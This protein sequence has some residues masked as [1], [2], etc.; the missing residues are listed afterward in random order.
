MPT[1][2]TTCLLF[3][4]VTNQSKSRVQTVNPFTYLCTYRYLCI[5]HRCLQICTSLEE[6]TLVR[7]SESMDSQ[8]TTLAGKNTHTMLWVDSTLQAGSSL[9]WQEFFSQVIIFTFKPKVL[10][11]F[12]SSRFAM[13]F[14]HISQKTSCS[15]NCWMSQMAKWGV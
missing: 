1:S 4:M 7:W 8:P 3:S 2:Q 13:R 10:Q 6:C 11:S 15:L 5:I 14:C 12:V 9:N